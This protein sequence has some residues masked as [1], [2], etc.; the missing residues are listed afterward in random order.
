MT[1]EQLFSTCLTAPYQ[2]T[3][4]QVN[5]A[6]LREDDTL[7]IFFEGSNGKTD[8]FRNLDFPAKPY[9]KM[10]KTVWYA[11]RGFLRAWKEVK[12][13]INEKIADPTLKKIV[14]AGYSHGAAIA[15]L[16][17]EYIWFH[18]RDLQDRLE[19]YGF[20]CPRVVWKP[21]ACKKRWTRF[22]VIR[23]LNDLITYLPPAFLGYRHVGQMI[24]IGKKGKYTPI[25]A[26]FSENI[27]TELALLS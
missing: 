8:W 20:G 21:S 9:H 18:R 27:L 17:Q 14:T 5:Y 23:N 26:H 12:P 22:S 3:G 24:K 11:H 13:I 4:N 1:L 19:G 6:F 2:E 7:Y 10:G 15:V 25:Q 16:C